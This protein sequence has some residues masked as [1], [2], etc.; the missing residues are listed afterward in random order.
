MTSTRNGMQRH[1]GAV[2][3]L[4]V[5]R[6]P[7][8]YARHFKGTRTIRVKF[9]ENRIRALAGPAGK[10]TSEGK[11][12]KDELVW[13]D[14]PKGFAIR[15]SAAATAGSL[16]H[17]TYLVQ[18][19]HAGQKRRMPIGAC[20]AISL[21]DAIK[22]AKAILGD[23]AR[24]RDPFAERKAKARKDAADAYTL[25]ALIDDW[26]ELKLKPQRKP[27]YAEEAPRAIQRVFK[28]CLDEPA[29]KIDSETVMRIHDAL[30]K[31]GKPIMAA[32]AVG[33]AS[34]AYGWA[35]E[36]R[37][38]KDNPFAKLP[39]APTRKRDRVLDDEELKRVWDALA[40]DS[41]F[42]AIARMLILTGQRREEVAG[43]TWDELSADGLTWTLP[44][45]RAKN[46]A[47]H[48]VPL[49][50][51]AQAIIAA[52]PRSNR[53]TLVFPGRLGHNTFNG[54]GN[55]KIALDRKSNVTDWVIHDLR[56]TVA[57]NLQKL[58]V[59]LEVTE[60]ILNHTSGSRSGIVGIYQRHDWKDEKRAA[61]QA[62]ADRLE[63]IV[64]GRTAPDN[65]VALRTA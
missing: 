10:L 5:R 26:A 41:G 57:T 23:A 1:E 34:A 4:R 8:G 37:K 7:S 61:L 33:Y 12:V 43:M 2:G 38:L 15:V 60:A 59:R 14:A 64:E 19:A 48:I 51:Q 49:S 28:R 16:D 22:E 55:A 63:A 42:D 65:V 46:S 58:G 18:Y 62:W 39:T 13:T 27:H 24:D 3:T 56:R 11:P 9:T 40:S 20:N 25:A 31:K 44:A 45:A 54:W 35:I 36:R 6:K 29:A 17:K 32:R 21:A 30:V 50:A 47:V 52:Q 53:T